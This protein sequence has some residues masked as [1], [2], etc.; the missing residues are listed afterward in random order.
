MYSIYEI[1]KNESIDDIAKNLNV[2]VEEILML[3]NNLNNVVEGQLII[4]PNNSKYDTY[5]VKKGDNL[6]NIA[7]KYNIDVKSIELLNGLKSNEYIY[8]NQKILIPKDNIYI[9]K[10]ND[11]IADLLNKGITI[12][13]LKNSKVNLQP[14]QIIFYKK[15]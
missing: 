7:K 15:D 1:K 8:P 4:I 13:D 10:D 14:E 12:E 2:S 11:T 6:Y 5:I 9:T 3:N